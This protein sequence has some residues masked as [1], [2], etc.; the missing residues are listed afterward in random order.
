[1]PSRK[2]NG[3]RQTR[4]LIYA[5]KRK[6]GFAIQVI[7]TGNADIDACTGDLNIDLEIID[8]RYVIMIDGSLMKSFVYDLSYIAAN[9]NFTT[10][11]YFSKDTQFF[12]IDR[13]DL[14]NKGLTEDDMDTSTYIRVMKNDHVY[15]CKTLHNYEDDTAYIIE[16]VRTKEFNIDDLIPAS[17][18]VS[19]SPSGSP[20]P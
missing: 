13:R 4:K 16:A 3:S 8:V 1:M 7:K 5:L 12:Y 11:G 2:Q 20:S 6:E 18:S 17:P 9:R 19:P 15:K 14:K 10:G